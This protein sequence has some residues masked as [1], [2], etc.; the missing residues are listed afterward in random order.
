MRLKGSDEYAIDAPAGFIDD[1]AGYHPRRT[2]WRWSAGLG[3]ADDGRPL[4]WNLVQGI[5]DAAGGSERRLWLDGQ[6]RELEPVEFAPDLSAVGG[7][8]FSEWSAREDHTNALLLRSDYRQ[9][10]G[11]FDGEV[12]GVRLREG[13]GVMEEHDVRW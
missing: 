4:A 7:L 1:T 5:N 6:E 8:R 13:Y 9:P 2:S 3:T 11:T 10:F 12:G